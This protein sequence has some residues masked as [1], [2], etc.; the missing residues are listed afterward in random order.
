MFSDMETKTYFKSKEDVI[1]MF[2]GL[3]VVIV[4]AVLIVN[5]VSRNKGR[6]SV[7]RQL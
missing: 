1:S 7:I 5:L 6:V 2:I 3:M 4:V